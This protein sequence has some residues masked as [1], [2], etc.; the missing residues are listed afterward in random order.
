MLSPQDMWKKGWYF[1]LEQLFPRTC[2]ICHQKCLVEICID[3]EKLCQFI[4]LWQEKL[5]LS[6]WSAYNYH[7]SIHAKLMKSIKYKGN[8]EII[9]ILFKPITLPDFSAIDY[10]VPVPLHK[11][12]YCERGFNQS[13]LIAESLAKEIKKEVNRNL[14]RKKDTKQQAKLNKEQRKLNVDG[15]FL[16][17]GESLEGKTILL[18]DDV[19]S[20]GATV[21]ACIGAL[22]SAGCTNYSIFCLFRAEK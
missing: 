19:V 3:C 5:E 15:S 1:F 12:K 17:K 7:E 21:E 2:M 13:L 11:R 9:S 6:I 22:K 18:V 4:P 16:W 14:L 8:N 20:T 10:I